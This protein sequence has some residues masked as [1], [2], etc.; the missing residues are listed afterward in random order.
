MVDPKPTALAK[1]TPK[2]ADSRVDPTDY[3]PSAKV[4]PE[5][6]IESGIRE[7]SKPVETK[8]VEPAVI[9]GEAIEV[10]PSFSKPARPTP[11]IVERVKKLVEPAAPKGEPTK[12]LSTEARRKAIAEEDARRM[13]AVRR[14]AKGLRRDIIGPAIHGLLL[15]KGLK[16][17]ETGEGAFEKLYD[18]A[19]TMKVV[20]GRRVMKS[21][22]ERNRELD[23]ASH[24]AY[25]LGRGGL[26]FGEW[27][28]EQW[29]KHPLISDILLTVTGIASIIA[30]IYFEELIKEFLK[31]FFNHAFSSAVPSSEEPIKAEATIHD[32]RNIAEGM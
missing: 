32:A 21:G 30:S 18:H 31:G 13:R 2:R 9:S 15:T 4:A 20:S 10:A 23:I 16:P 27:C 19:L 5:P 17:S 1:F 8:P 22:E 14:Y 7:A 26:S 3:T 12:K 24:I 25:T 29:V 28:S 6:A 11:S